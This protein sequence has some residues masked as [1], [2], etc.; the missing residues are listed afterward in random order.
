MASTNLESSLRHQSRA[1]YHNHI[2]KPAIRLCTDVLQHLPVSS[3]RFGP[4]K[5]VVA[6]TRQWIEDESLAPSKTVFSPVHASERLTFSS[7]QTVETKE[8]FYEFYAQGLDSPL[9]KQDEVG[10]TYTDLPATFVA[11]IPEGRAYGCDGAV[12]TPSDHLLGDLSPEYT[13]NRYI[14]Q[15]HTV[16]AQMHLPKAS[17]VPGSTAVLASLG[18]QGYFAH[19][20]MD[21][22]PRIGLLK[23]AGFS[24][25]EIDNFFVNSPVLPYQQETLEALG[26]PL[27]KVIDC[28]VHPHI[29]AEHLIVPSPVSGVFASS[30]ET[31]NFLMRSFLDTT[32]PAETI[33][34][35]RIYVSRA[36]TTHRR[37]INESEV[38]KI[39][40]THGFVSV[41]PQNFSL[42]E[43]AHL[44]A[45]AEAVVMSLG[46]A[47]ANIVYCQAGAKII[48]I[49]NP[50][51][52]QACTWAAC[53]QRQAEYYF[54]FAQ[55]INS[56]EGVLSEDLSVD[57]DKLIQ[58]INLAN[59]RPT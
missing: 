52:V 48:E 59:I 34:P 17:Y 53:S 14:A 38:V 7:L 26:I 22:L 28:A 13:A 49:L 30:S 40:S 37:I 1:L 5:G 57:I 9:L 15:K 32:S 27:A 10:N 43:Q 20:M 24:L 25:G 44:F 56:N 42:A 33:R 18:A 6:S 2:R 3:E 12:I 50:R 46:S 35:S 55:G 51:S 47:M 19:W 23:S 45:E 29:K 11:E 58:T 36:N 21:M 39:L 8:D 41:E 4:P 31:C 54:M 16:L